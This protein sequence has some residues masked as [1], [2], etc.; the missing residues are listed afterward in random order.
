MT[1]PPWVAG[2]AVSVVTAVATATIAAQQ[3]R[4]PLAFATFPQLFAEYRTGDWQAAAGVGRA[5]G[6]G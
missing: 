2:A 4:V 6:R 1:R 3:A 5:A